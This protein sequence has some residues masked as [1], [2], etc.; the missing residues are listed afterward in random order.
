MEGATWVFIWALYGQLG[1]GLARRRF[2]SL[3]TTETPS[4]LKV[5]TVAVNKRKAFDLL[6]RLFNTAVT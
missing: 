5:I 4:P 2:S 1:V 6:M 3:D